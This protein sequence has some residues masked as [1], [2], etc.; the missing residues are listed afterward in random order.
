[1]PQKKI[2]RMSYDDYR[3]RFKAEMARLQ[4]RYCDVLKLWRG[5][6]HKPCRHARRCCGDAH[7]C[8][9]RSLETI[10]RPV[11]WQAR[12]QI[13]TKEPETHGRAER[14]VRQFMPY[15]FYNVRD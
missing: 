2:I 10:P 12:Q 13:M 4:R 3:A 11:L 6:R 14:T 7:V 5:C 9:Q 8:L 1:M 15:D